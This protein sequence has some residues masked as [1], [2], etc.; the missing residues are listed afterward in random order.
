VQHSFFPSSPFVIAHRGASKSAPE[1][2]ISAFL[3]AKAL[4]LSWVELDVRLTA[5]G[6]VIVFHDDE[7]QRTTTGCGNVQAY[8]YSY[9]KTLD[10][11]SWF[12]PDFAYEYIPTLEEVLNCL[13]THQMGVNIEIKKLSIHQTELVEKVMAILQ[14]QS[15][16]IPVLLSSFSYSSLL[17][18]RKKSSEAR[19]GFL[20]DE[21]LPHWQSQCDELNA[22]T[23]NVNQTILN[24]T[25]VQAIKA[26]KRLVLAYTVNEISR[27][28]QLF[29]WGVEG[30]FSDCPPDFLTAIKGIE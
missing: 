29:A 8:P 12:N 20:M 22:E 6:E 26:S 7:L 15:L 10:A 23:V 2:T 24:E 11:G 21:W 25:R 16:T 3:K 27:A 19:I 4:G 30:L 5:E 13:N 17:F 28:K 14:K 18:I 1:N 9:L